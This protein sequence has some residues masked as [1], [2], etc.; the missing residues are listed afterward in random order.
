MAVPEQGG[1]GPAAGGAEKWQTVPPVAGA[2]RGPGSAVAVAVSFFRRCAALPGPR[3]ELVAP[4]LR[5][6]LGASVLCGGRVRRR[7]VGFSHEGREQGRGPR[8]GLGQLLLPQRSSPGGP[9]ARQRELLFLGFGIVPFPLFGGGKSSP[10]QQ[11]FVFCLLS[12]SVS[13]SSLALCLV[14]GRCPLCCHSCCL[15]AVECVGLHQC[16]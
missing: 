7:P 5:K 13:Q 4:F 16:R 11:Q 10:S 15:S 2:S 14:C 9:L 3:G 12:D 6:E 8:G 1:A